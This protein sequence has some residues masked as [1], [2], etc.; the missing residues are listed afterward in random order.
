MVVGNCV[1]ILVEDEDSSLSPFEKLAQDMQNVTADKKVLKKVL[2]EGVGELVPEGALCKVH[3]NGYLEYQDEPFDSSRLRKKVHQFRLGRGEVIYG[4]DVGMRTMRK[5]E[6]SKFLISYHYAYGKMGCP[7]RIP[8]EAS[9]LFEV[10]L[11]S[12]ISYCYISPPFYHNIPQY[13]NSDISSLISLLKIK[14]ICIESG[15]SACRE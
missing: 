1:M 13:T 7:P 4:W 2:R 9:V 6:I 12:L 15:R 8:P 10:S 3:Y 14:S 5:D 11:I